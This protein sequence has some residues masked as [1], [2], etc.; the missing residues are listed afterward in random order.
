MKIC[1]VNGCIRKHQA[2]GYCK[3]HYQQV[4]LN[5]KILERTNKDMNEYWFENNICYIQIYGKGNEKKCVAEIDLEDYERVKDYKWYVKEKNYVYN[6]KL[7]RLSRY[8]LGITNPKLDTDHE[9]HDTLNNRKY[10]IRPCTRTQNNANRNKRKDNTSGYKGVMWC[11]RDKR[12]ITQIGINGQL[13]HLGSYTDKREAAKRYNKEAYKL[14]G[15]FAVLN[16]V[17]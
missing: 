4:Y 6:C 1:S 17:L 14:W 9:D 5:G 10:N 16:K 7:G 3:K 13:V 15:N 2:K 12:W 11:A 8:L